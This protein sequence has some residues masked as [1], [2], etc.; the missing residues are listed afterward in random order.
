[1]RFPGKLKNV[2]RVSHGE[3]KKTNLLIDIRVGSCRNIH[4]FPKR[5]R[6][7]RERRREKKRERRREKRSR[8]RQQ[9]RRVM[10]NSW[11]E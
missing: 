7:R 1:M 6:R 2:G 3:E 4:F 9:R 8:M 5:R 10:T 11:M